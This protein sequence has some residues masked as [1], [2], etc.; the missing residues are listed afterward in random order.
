MS[1]ACG[2]QAHT[3]SPRE[4]A[5][6]TSAWFGQRPPSRPVTWQAYGA[7]PREVR[8]QRLAR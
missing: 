6:F 1:S 8:A 4:S 5:S 3:L 2:R 7:P